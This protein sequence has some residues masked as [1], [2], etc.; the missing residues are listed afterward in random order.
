MKEQV[1]PRSV[2]RLVAE[3]VNVAAIERVSGAENA[4][5]VPLDKFAKLLGT[6][7][8]IVKGTLNPR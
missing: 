3:I 4:V 7:K 5:E 2:L 1:H 8:V 6:K